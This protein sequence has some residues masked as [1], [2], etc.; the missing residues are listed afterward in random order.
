MNRLP[1][2]VRSNSA[3]RAAALC[4]LAC[5]ATVVSA[6]GEK[7]YGV[8][9]W[10]FNGWQVG[11]GPTGGWSTETVVTHSEPWWQAGFFAP[12]YQTINQ[13]H[14]AA[15]ITRIDYNWGETI[16][17][18]GNPHRAT[19]VNSVLGVVGT[20]GAQSRVWIIGNEPNII[21]EG[22][23][24]ADNRITPTGYADVYHEIRSAI[25]AERPNDEVLVA[26]PSPGGVIPGVR[27][28]AG[29]DWLSQTIAAIDALPGA[30]VDGFAI[31]A[32]GNPFVGAAA[33]VQAFRTDYAAQLA[34][35][36]SH[37]H[38]DKPVYLTE[39]N[40]ST[41]LTGNLAVNEQVTADFIRGAYADV[42]AWNHT[43]GNHNIVS[44]SWFVQNQNYGSGWNQ[45]SLDYWQTAGNP[46][47]HPGDL[48]TATLEAAQYPAGLKGTRPV[49][50]PP[51]GDFNSDGR[52]D[53]ADLLIWQRGYGSTAASP[54]QG[55]A[56]ADGRVDGADLARWRPWYGAGAIPASSAAVPEPL[57]LA[58][59]TV[60]LLAVVRRSVSQS[61]PGCCKRPPGTGARAPRRSRRQTR[62]DADSPRRAH[63]SSAGCSAGGVSASG[64]R[65]GSSANRSIVC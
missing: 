32:Y 61:L 27:W 19:W 54:W 62:R 16:P 30:G 7:L 6:N 20:L 21:G 63:G 57:S 14:G 24:W 17:A 10:N 49:E 5:H 48:W 53:G 45:Y 34:V 26:L 28:M 15:I 29:N 64:S 56:T 11:A 65:S 35:I 60:A 25:K 41:S 3:A 38:Q 12:L 39:W 9:W 50:G 40:R 42:N 52:I 46:V 59:A 1:R 43:P 13:Q 37:G 4:L 23:G 51:A 44:L 47:G 22:N 8:H 33:A 58:L 36:D 18:P 31:H 55:D 2:G